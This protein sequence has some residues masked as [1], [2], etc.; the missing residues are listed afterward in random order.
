MLILVCL[1]FLV[2]GLFIA[3]S[4]YGHLVS[5][6]KKYSQQN[7]SMN[8]NGLNFVSACIDHFKLNTKISIMDGEFD[9]AYLTKRDI[10]L[11]T[12]QVATGKTVADISIAGH[13][14]G[15]AL[16]KKDSS[17][18]F[19]LNS[20]FKYLN[21]LINFLL[22]IA[23]LTAIAF[24]FVSSLREYSTIVFYVLL[25]LWLLTVIIKIAVIPLELDASKRAY[26]ILS[27]NKFLTKDELKQTKQVLNAAALTYV[28]SLFFGLYKLIKKIQLSFRRN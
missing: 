2:V 12:K 21:N 18:L 28:G 14:L 19:K 15:H 9:D 27:D 7:A 8:V 11:L 3:G 23:F 6:Y 20:F 22:P 26:K 16:Q 17:G 5:V 25:G 13:E 4:S 1:I 24:L 10:I